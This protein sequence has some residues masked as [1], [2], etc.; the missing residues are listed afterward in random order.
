MR[1]SLLLVCLLGSLGLVSAQSPAGFDP[2][3]PHPT[4]QYTAQSDSMG[5]PDLTQ[6]GQAAPPHC[7]Q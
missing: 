5:L 7:P 2:N 3:H 4:T 6:H 1:S